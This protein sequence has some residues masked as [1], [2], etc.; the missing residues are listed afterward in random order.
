MNSK[1]SQIIFPSRKNSILV[2][3]S[4]HSSGDK[5]NK[6]LNLVF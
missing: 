1:I 3:L 5:D 4:P 6:S 2:S